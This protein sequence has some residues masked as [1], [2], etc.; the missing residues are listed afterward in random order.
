M[1]IADLVHGLES[2]SRSRTG[3]SFGNLSPVAAT[4]SSAADNVT[5]GDT[6]SSTSSARVRGRS[7]SHY[8][9]AGSGSGVGHS[10]H[11]AAPV[12]SPAPPSVTPTSSP[13]IHLAPLR[14]APYDGATSPP[15]PHRQHQG[16]V[17]RTQ[18]SHT[19]GA[20]SG[21]H[22]SGSRGAGASA[23]H[24]SALSASHVPAT[25][26]SATQD[27][28]SPPGSYAHAPLA[29]PPSPHSLGRTSAHSYADHGSSAPVSQQPH[30]PAY[31]TSYGAPYPPYSSPP[32]SS[33]AP[34]QAA[35]PQPQYRSS[36]YSPVSS[37]AQASGPPTAQVS[38]SSGLRDP[39]PPSSQAVAQAV[40]PLALP[41]V[42]QQRSMS[43][44]RTSS[45]TGGPA[46]ESH[47]SPPT[48]P[49]SHSRTNQP[50]SSPTVA[51]PSGGSVKVLKCE[52]C[53]RTFENK[54]TFQSHNS[55]FHR[56]SKTPAKPRPA[57]FTCQYCHKCKCLSVGDH[58]FLTCAASDWGVCTH[59][60]Q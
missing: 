54:A 9:H 16:H 28:M 1:D 36:S 26:R 32:P 57:S 29:V 24:G 3:R 6:G 45:S 33:T 49:P 13:L 12:S 10:S 56:R 19:Y 23:E 2:R 44:H 34:P 48:A 20:P 21:A 35:P 51:V 30:G 4:G 52:L 43:H 11:P 15:P 37:A 17:Q 25:S 58:D 18:S 41:P 5:G 46:V 39:M 31:P 8:N 60:D 40:S 55:V 38:G 59:R 42:S 47:S 27:L 22:N 14:S 53:D 7:S 50:G